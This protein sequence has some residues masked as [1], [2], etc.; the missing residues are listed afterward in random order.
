MGWR[1][2]IV[3]G[4]VYGI[5]GACVLAALLYQRWTNP[6]AVREQIIAKLGE[7]FPALMSASILPG[8]AFSEVSN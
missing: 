3:R 6:S 1:K 2:W 7:A 8:C 5:T 4:V